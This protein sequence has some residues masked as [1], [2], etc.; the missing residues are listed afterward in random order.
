MTNFAGNTTYTITAMATATSVTV[1]TASPFRKF[2]MIQNNSGANIAINFNGA[3]LTGI[4]P[5]STNLCYVLPSTAGNNVVR[6]DNGFVPAGAITAYQTSGS[7][8]NTLVV[9]EG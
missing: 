3:T 8:I 4:T 7:P 9:I 6:F 2:L 1:A 5:T